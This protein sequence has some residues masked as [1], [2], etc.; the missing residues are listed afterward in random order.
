MIDLIIYVLELVSVILIIHVLF[1]SRIRFNFEIVVS[2]VLSICMIVLTNIT[3]IPYISYIAHI[4]IFL[5][6][7]YEFRR[8]LLETVLRFACCI[9]VIAIFESVLLMEVNACLRTYKHSKYVYMC[10]SF[11]MLICGIVFYWFFVH[12]NIKFEIDMKDKTFIVLVIVINVFVLYV[13]EDGY[14]SFLRLLICFIS[15]SLLIVRFVVIT[16]RGHEKLSSEEESK[17]PKYSEQYE[18]L[19][20]EVRKRQHDYKNEIQTIKM[21][22]ATG[23]DEIALGMIKEYEESE[24]Y[25][26]ILNG[27]ENPIIAGL[28][29]SKIKE[30]EQQGVKMQCRILMRDIRLALT[31]RDIID[32]I[33]IL[34]DNAFECTSKQEKKTMQFVIEE[35]EKGISI[36][37]SNPSCYIP[38]SE[39]T[40]IF[41]FGYSTKGSNRGIGLH[42]VRELVKQCNGDIIAGNRTVEDTNYFDM[43]VVI[44][45]MN[46][47]VKKN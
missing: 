14:G 26:S 27:C 43:Q 46:R 35:T 13:K 25:T 11:V 2:F 1:H 18:M 47:H 41:S 42:T 45:F 40:K 8:T 44:P 6:C 22:C 3:Q 12:K 23:G 4:I 20:Q 30:F 17:I 9:T 29:Y 19:I 39:I 33:G 21:V 28:V 31:I 37:T 10:I 24:Q 34:L 38:S 15:F 32:V 7:L 16:K 36:T 5:Y